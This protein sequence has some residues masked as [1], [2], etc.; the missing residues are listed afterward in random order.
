MAARVVQIP[1]GSGQWYVSTNH[2]GERKVRKAE[3]QKEAEKVA[4]EINETIRA[5]KAGVL[6]EDFSL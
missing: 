2:R 1:K 5:E 4:R 6:R 3:N